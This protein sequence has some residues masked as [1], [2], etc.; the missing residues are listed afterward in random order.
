[1]NYDELMDVFHNNQ[2]ADKL[3]E[4]KRPDQFNKLIT[5]ESFTK[6]N[7]FMK[8]ID[9]PKMNFRMSFKQNEKNKNQRDRELISEIKSS[10]TSFN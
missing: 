3:E 9:A 4:K 5:D 2:Q 8:S 6:K 7:N 10:L 1:M